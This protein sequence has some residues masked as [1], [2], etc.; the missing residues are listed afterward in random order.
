MEKS[1]QGIQGIGRMLFSQCTEV[2]NPSTNRGL[3][4]NLV[5]EDPSLA[6]IFKGTDL[7]IAA[8][9]AELGFLAHSV[10]HVQT[11]GMGN[12]SL[13]SLALVSARY[14]N[15]ANEVLTQLMAA[16]MIAVCQTLDLRVMHLQFLELYQPQFFELV[17]AHWYR[18]RRVH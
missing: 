5:A 7:N 15:T 11:A 18:R 8:L 4:P 10:N 1:R 6:F 16:H 14:T 13:N 12:Q 17:A 9:T 3:P 2:I